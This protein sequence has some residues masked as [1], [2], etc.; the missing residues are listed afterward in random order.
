MGLVGGMYLPRKEKSKSY[1]Q[2]G[3]ETGLGGSD[4]YG[5]R[6]RGEGGDTERERARTKGH[7]R[8]F[9]ETLK[10]IHI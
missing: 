1:G 2:M 6:K 9:M 8:G 7:L 5:E 4:G 10:H 3:A